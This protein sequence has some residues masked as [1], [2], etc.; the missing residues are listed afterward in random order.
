MSY[1]IPRLDKQPAESRLYTFDFSQ[2]MLTGETVAT[3]DS[4]TATPSG[5]TLGTAVASGQRVQNRISAGVTN[6]QYKIT[7]VVTTSLGNVLEGEAN[8]FVRDI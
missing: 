2:L 5:L 4:F 3:I 7:V 1:A 6:T 8:L